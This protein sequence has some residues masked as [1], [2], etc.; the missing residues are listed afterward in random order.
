M[1]EQSETR[2][3]I[4]RVAEEL[5]MRHGYVGVSM[6]LLVEQIARQR[7]L[8]KPAIYY[9]FSDKEALYVAVLL[10]VAARNGHQLRAAAT[11]HGSLRSQLVALAEVLGRLEP[12]SLTRMRLDIAEHVGAAARAELHQAFQRDISGPI[13]AVFEHTARAGEL[14]PGLSA[15][16][17]TAAFLGLVSSLVTRVGTERRLEAAG[18]AA[19]VLLKGV[20]HV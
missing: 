15:A 11:A 20:L 19:D 8:T 16:L 2:Q 18:L 9:H 6:R 10:D 3:V 1:G 12:E 14:R 5:F 4:L 7:R 17:A 13:Y